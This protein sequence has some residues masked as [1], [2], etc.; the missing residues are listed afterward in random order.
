VQASESVHVLRV[1][2]SQYTGAYS[3]NVFAVVDSGEAVLIDAGL[4]DDVS[5]QS[6]LDYLK[7][8]GDPRVDLIVITHHHYDHAG[9]ANRLR[10]ATGSRIAM[11]PEEERL[12]RETLTRPPRDNSQQTQFFRA[13][14]AKVTADQPL[15]DGDILKAGRLTLRV[16]LTP[17]HSAGHVSVL[18][19]EEGVLFSGDNVLGLGTTAI[20]PPPDGDMGQYVESLKRMKALN[21]RLICPGHGPLVHQPERKLQDLI[22]HRHE[23]EEQVLALL[24]EGKRTP[25]EMVR[26]IYPELDPRL[27]R[28]AAGQVLSHLYKLRDEGR[29]SLRQEG[30][31]YLCEL[32]KV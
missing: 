28:M 15:A 23:R 3:P 5:V 30:E 27:E 19:E 12:L 8:I 6:R 1:N 16:I 4:P 17:G 26:V 25:R 9:G 22:E 20:P 31:E 18:L 10:E 7:S 13:E 32:R 24:R 2:V 29:V 14:V 11:N 21:A